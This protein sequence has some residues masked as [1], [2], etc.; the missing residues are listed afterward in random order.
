MRDLYGE[1]CEFGWVEVDDAGFDV[2]AGVDEGEEVGLAARESVG[3][4][5]VCR[6]EDVRDC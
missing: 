2:M 6:V 1:V 3:V 5:G 4:A